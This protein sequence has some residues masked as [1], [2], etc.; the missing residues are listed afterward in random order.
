MTSKNNTKKID[1]NIKNLKDSVVNNK[2]DIDSNNTTFN[3]YKPIINYKSPNND[4]EI[5][6]IITKMGNNFVQ[7]IIQ[8]GKLRKPTEYKRIDN[9]DPYRIEDKI[10]YN[11]VEQ[12][13]EY[14]EE[15]LS[16][17]NVLKETIENQGMENVN[18]FYTYFNQKYRVC[19]MNKT[20]NGGDQV[21]DYVVNEAINS[22]QREQFVE[23]DMI[24]T[25]AI[26]FTLH[27]FIECHIL[28][29]PPNV[30]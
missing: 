24:Q 21:I 25:T 16:I 8:T 28:E 30:D 9:T 4:I 17:N 29:K 12:Y 10:E 15:A 26:Y 20:L 23:P 5:I 2:T 11:K 3:M 22:I 18:T 19:K 27:A 6:G 14:I 1:Q 7:S 13:K